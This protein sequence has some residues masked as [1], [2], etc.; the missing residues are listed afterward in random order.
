MIM[1]GVGGCMSRRGRKRERTDNES[2]VDVMQVVEHTPMTIS[3]SP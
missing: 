1:G 2:G 3:F